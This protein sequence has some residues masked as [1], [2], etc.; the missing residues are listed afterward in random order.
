[1]AEISLENLSYRYPGQDPREANILDSVNLDIEKGEMVA[2]QGPSGSGKS[3]LLYVL[4]GLLRGYGGTVRIK[5]VD[6]KALSESQL[7]SLRNQK[8]GFVFQQFHLLPKSTVLENVM[9]PAQYRMGPK[10][11]SDGAERAK[12]LISRL[13]LQGREHATPNELSGGQQQRAAICRALLNQTDIILADEP[14]GSLDSSNSGQIMELL[15][16]ANRE[17]RTV[18]IITHDSE[19]AA[20]CDRIIFFRDGRVT[21]G[22]DKG[23]SSARKGADT[24]L[25]E[26]VQS[27]SPRT[28]RSLVSKEILFTSLS[29]LRRNRAR[30]VLTMI[31]IVIGVA[32]VLSMVTVGQ[33]TKNK[34][35]DSYAELGVRSLLL[36]GYSNWE[37]RAT[38]EVTAKFEAFDWEK[39]ILPLRKIFTDI[40][41]LSPLLQ[42]WQNQV[43]FGGKRLK[44]NVQLIGVSEQGLGVSKRPVIIGAPFSRYHVE[45][46]SSVCLIGFDIYRRFFSSR[47]PLGEVIHINQDN[48]SF[49]CR[50]IGVLESSQSNKNW[51]TP[52]L[53]IYVPYTYFQ[54]VGSIWN[55]KIHHLL[56]Q[57]APGAGIESTGDAIKAYFERK[58]G[59]SIKVNVGSDSKLIAQMNRFLSLFT[60]LLGAIAVVALGV[61]GMGITNMMLVSVAERFREIGVRKAFGATNLGIRYQYLSEA[62]VICSAAGLMGLLL[63]FISYE[64]AIFGASKWIDSL[65][66]E[67]VFDRWAIVTS[68]V[69]I[70]AVGLLSGLAPA[71]KAERLEVIEALRSE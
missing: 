21:E 49:P 15:R 40:H 11:Q 33:F 66:F 10:N 1:M 56:L 54:A 23:K 29:N 7:A 24:I 47:D 57:V 31:G 18:V 36:Y 16:E 55:G 25:P 42:H 2:I 61:G 3:T 20:A 8:I 14:T 22:S 13:G 4:G 12:Q 53:E 26:S 34:I 5:G 46:R 27:S 69:S 6:L 19:V 28:I 64:L 43:S 38:D 17:G 45:K 62:V 58:Y 71:I 39:D 67:W 44:E 63:G 50:V 9:L 48:R 35:M 68:L 59:K 30:T 32:A 70:V 41:L 60:L 52:N 65:K 37:M 51:R